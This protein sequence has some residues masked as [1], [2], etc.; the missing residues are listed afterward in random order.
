MAT[1]AKFRIDVAIHD[2]LMNSTERPPAPAEARGLT[3]PQPTSP[4]P[5]QRFNDP[6]PDTPP[7]KRKWGAKDVYRYSRGWLGPY[8]RSRVLPGEV[9]P[10][11][12]YLFVEYKCNLGCGFGCSYSNKVKGMT[13]HVARRSSD[14][15][16]DNG[17]RVVPL[18][19]GEPLL[20]PEF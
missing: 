3:L 15:L 7:E 14:W 16:H 8:V 19:G 1:A 13:E 11:T 4:P 17:C 10:I 5:P 18:M 6:G 9:Q 12:A 2:L 20:R